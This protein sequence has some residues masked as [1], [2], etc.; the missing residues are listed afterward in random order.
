L[1]KVLVGLYFFLEKAIAKL[2]TKFFQKKAKC[3]K[4]LK[5]EKIQ[6]I[7]H[8]SILILKMLEDKDAKIKNTKLMAKKIIVAVKSSSFGSNTCP[9][10]SQVT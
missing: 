5:S 9:I 1:I 8:L 3:Q 10:V 7:G 2:L 4:R 6:F